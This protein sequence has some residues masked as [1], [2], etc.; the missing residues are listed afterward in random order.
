MRSCTRAGAG[1]RRA[2]PASITPAVN[3]AKAGTA[4]TSRKH[5]VSQSRF[6][7]SGNARQSPLAKAQLELGT[8]GL[9][10][11]EGKPP[12]ACR[13]LGYSVRWGPRGRR[14]GRGRASSPGE[15]ST[16]WDSPSPKF[17]MGGS[18]EEKYDHPTQ[19]PIRE[20]RNP[21]DDP[22]ARAQQRCGE[23]TRTPHPRACSR[24]AGGLSPVIPIRPAGV[25]AMVRRGP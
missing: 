12:A 7:S 11:G 13:S 25:G 19:K 10:S 8:S 9:M 6:E 3:R 15:N 17:I 1:T 5:Q 4:F 14:R 24:R 2:L 18:G 21:Q 22:C 23:A 20:C 16:V